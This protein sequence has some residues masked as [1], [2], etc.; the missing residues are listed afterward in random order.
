MRAILVL[1]IAG[2]ICGVSV[3][4]PLDG[5]TIHLVAGEYKS[6]DVPISL[7]CEAPETAEQIIV[8]EPKTGKAMP[9][10]LRNGELVFVCEGAMPNTEHDYVVKA[11]KAPEGYTPKV[12]V[13]K[14]EDADVVDVFIED[15]FFTSYHYTNDNRKPFLWPV[16]TEGGVGITR[17][18]PMQE[19]FDFIGLSEKEAE[20]LTR[21]AKDHVHHKSLWVSY[22]D[23]NGA[24]C[25]GEGGNGGYQNSGEVTWG[26]G[27]AYGW[28][29]AKNVWQ[30]KDHAALISEER[31]YRFYAVPEKGRLIDTF[32]TFTADHGVVT[33]KDTKE[34]GICTVRMRPELTGRN[35]DITNAH[36]DKGEFKCW[37]KPSPWCDYSGELKGVG[38]RGLAIFDAPT[39]LRHPTSWH[40]RNYG[41]MAANCF[42]YSYF[43]EK[44]YNK[45][46][47]PGNGD[48]TM[49]EGDC[50]AFKYR[51]YVH[52]G[53]VEKAAVADRY[54]DF[55]TP[56]KAAWTEA[57]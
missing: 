22:G 15:V 30:D 16:L 18:W 28:V 44:D 6:L 20:Y 5:R 19:D 13:K 56:P 4:G 41:L 38:W 47:I 48:L 35:A 43:V 53:D 29:H 37:G 9:A 46:L 26:S 7:P 23:L 39:N 36:G 27:D 10:M 45:G 25:W 33:W 12:V 17:D 40:V 54:A 51:V 11:G 49:K 52:A 42:G 50:L 1:L 3:A 2:M 31:E 24:D 21:K 55:A 8:V 57:K 34:G 14:R 32:V